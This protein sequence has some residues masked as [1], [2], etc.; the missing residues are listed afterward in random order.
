[1]SSCT[2]TMAR[3]AERARRHH[4]AEHQHDPRPGH[5]RR[6][7]GRVRASRARRW[8]WR[9][10]GHLLFTRFLKHDPTD[11]GWPDRDRFVLSAGHASMLLYALLHLSGYDLPLDE[12]KRFRRLGSP[13]PGHPERGLT[14]GVEVTTGPLGQG[15]ANAVGMAIAER[16]L[17]RALQPARPRHRRPPHLRGLL[18]RRPDGGRVRR[19]G[20]AGRQPAPRQA[21]RLLRRQPHH[22]RG[23][24]R[25]G[26]L[27]ARWARRFEAYGW[28]VAPRRRRE[29]P[30]R[31]GRR[32]STAAVAEEQPPVAPH[33]RIGDRLRRA[34]QGRDGRGPRGTAGRRRGPEGQAQPGLA[35][36]GAL[37]R[38]RR[39]PRS[40]T[41]RRSSRSGQTLPRRRGGT[42]SPPTSVTTP[43]SPR[44]FRR[45]MRGRATTRMGRVAPARSRRTWR[46]APRPAGCS[47]RWPV[48]YPSWSAA[49]Q[50]SPRRPTPTS[51]GRATSRAATSV[52]ATS[53]SGCGSTPW[54]RSSTAWLHTAGCG[55]SGRR[56]SSSRTTCGRR[57][58]W[59]R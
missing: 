55:R 38:A 27:R 16:M 37:R 40:S 53:T 17:A 10:S 9:R 29:R 13:L 11:P 52:A 35:V 43:C 4:R 41:R 57:S 46:P 19:G 32:R 47:T 12:L 30:R 28:Q 36:R 42:G 23:L 22:D 49:R 21:D 58:G 3:A 1:M 54:A 50:I 33:R 18:R 39:G 31:A 24:D 6:R 15:F 5:R 34:E 14:P 26:V 20:L 59:R 7:G 2:G 45:V 44:E 56:S 48:G 8:P 51:R 25:P